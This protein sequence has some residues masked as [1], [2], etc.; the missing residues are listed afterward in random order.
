MICVFAAF[1]LGDLRVLISVGH[2]RLADSFRQWRA[3]LLAWGYVDPGIT[4]VS[5]GRGTHVAEEDWSMEF[6]LVLHE[7][8]E[9]MATEQQRADAVQR[10]GEYAM[11][12]VGDGTLKEGA[13][14]RPAAEATW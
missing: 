3:C 11:G 7:D 4:L 6:M 9:L 14:L 10:V 1:V 8:P 5:Y 12:L 13:P 2:S